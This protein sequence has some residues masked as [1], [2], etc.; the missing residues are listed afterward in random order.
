MPPPDLY[1]ALVL[2]GGPAG[3]TAGLVMARAGLR[4]LLVERS[5]FPRFHI[6]E[7]L[8]PRNMP[9]I[10]KLGLEAALAAV[11][12]MDKR[13]AE[14][15]TG[16]ERHGAR[17]HFDTALLAGDAAGDNWAWNVERA[18]FDAALL[19]AARSAGVEV[20][21]GR[22]VRGISRLSDGAVAVSLDG[23]GEAHGRWLVDATG[24]ATLVGRH[25]GL[26]RVIP[27]LRK[28]AY[29]AHFEGVRRREGVEGGFPVIVV[30]EEGWFWLIPLDESRTSVGLVLDAD[31]AHRTGVPADRRLAWGVAR[32]PAVCERMA[33]ASGPETNQVAA[34]FS[35][36]CAPYA[37][38]G[39]FLAGDA[40]TFVDPIFST[41][42]CLA[43]MSGARAGEGIADIL[44]RGASPEKV[45]ESYVRWFEESSSIFFHL[46]ERYYQPAFRDLFLSGG[47]PLRIHQA[48]LA[49]LAGNVFPRPPFALRWRLRLFDLLVRLQRYVPVGPRHE[50]F[51][52][53]AAPEP[54]AGS[55]EPAG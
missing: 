36:R 52:L 6:G 44:R 16:D 8:L 14:F 12:R 37:G 9:L 10:R 17:F 19:D 20:V 18:S 45:R 51:S 38:P 55:S 53:F 47:G 3:A 26:R 4:V 21:H 33:A 1:D 22:A 41:G 27:H 39:Y 35:Y 31:A 49:V 13:G 48:V 40:A 54:A 2:G 5:P 32:C 42:V 46:V 15:V 7:S 29:F 24:Q 30:C 43:M 50:S 34:D 11:P 28:A 23:G 25:L